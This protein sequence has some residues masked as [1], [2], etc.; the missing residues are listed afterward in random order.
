[1]SYNRVIQKKRSSRFKPS[2]TTISNINKCFHISNLTRNLFSTTCG[3]AKSSHHHHGLNYDYFEYE[4]SSSSS[5][6]SIN[7]SENRPR[8]TSEKQHHQPATSTMI[9]NDHSALID[10]S[11][12]KNPGLVYNP[13]TDNYTVSST[14]AGED[15]WP[16][17][18]YVTLASL[19]S[20]NQDKLYNSEDYLYELEQD[21]EE[22]ETVLSANSFTGTATL[23]TEYEDI[24]IKH[25]NSPISAYTYEDVSTPPSNTVLYADD[26]S[27]SDGGCYLHS[28]ELSAEEKGRFCNFSSSSSSM[29][30]PVSTSTS[31]TRAGGD[32]SFTNYDLQEQ[33]QR[34]SDTSSFQLLSSSSNS[35]EGE[36][37]THVC[38]TNYEATFVGDLTVHFADAIQIVRD[39]CDEWLYVRVAS[40][41]REG[42]VPRTIVMDLKQFVEQLVRAKSSLVSKLLD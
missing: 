25:N 27:N 2:T 14:G 7:Q 4:P 39:N 28:T 24:T 42:Y 17:P 12:N 30:S 22:E 21:N 37:T 15:D 1:M 29:T 10:N 18:N 33:Q 41:G 35:S 40:D 31:F 13:A 34:F 5:S 23:R 38:A 3:G 11:F 32:Y 19:T 26:S 6:T 36:A 20:G 9:E 16:G 8:F